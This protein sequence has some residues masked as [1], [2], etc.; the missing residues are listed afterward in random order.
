MDAAGRILVTLLA[1]RWS[2]LQRLPAIRSYK[3]SPP[4]R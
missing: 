2:H 1:C 3:V 4:S